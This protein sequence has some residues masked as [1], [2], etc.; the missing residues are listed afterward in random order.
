MYAKC[1][2]RLM[3]EN[4]QHDAIFRCGHLDY[5]VARTCEMWGLG[6]KGTRTIATNAT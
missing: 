3:L 6:A 4:V 5:N 1:G 2:N